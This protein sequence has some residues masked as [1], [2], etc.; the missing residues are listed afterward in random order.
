[1]NKIAILLFLLRVFQHGTLKRAIWATMG[2]CVAFAVSFFFAT[3]FQCWPINHAWLQLEEWHHGYCN[4]VHLQGWLSAAI[5]I[6]LDVIILV[7]PIHELCHLQ[8][9]IKKKLLLVV[10]FSLGIL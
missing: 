8:M 5:N 4:Q 1:M 10:I 6:V 3:L 2:L 9:N 7:L